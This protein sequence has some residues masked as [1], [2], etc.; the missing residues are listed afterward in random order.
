MNKTKRN[1]KMQKSFPF[2]LL[3]FFTLCSYSQ[4]KQGLSLLV[5]QHEMEKEMKQGGN[6]TENFIEKHAV[7]KHQGVDYLSCMAVVSPNYCPSKLQAIGVRAGEKIG[8]F[9]TLRI[10]ISMITPDLDLPG[11]EY[12]DIARKINPN[13]DKALKD[14]R[15]DSAHLGVFLPAPVSGKN[16]II[17][18]TDWGFDYTHP[19]FYDTALTNTRILAAWDQFRH[20]GPSPTGFDYGTV[21]ENEAQLFAA[22]CDT[23]NIYQYATHGSHVAGIAAGSGAGTIYKGVA[24]DA[25]LLFATFLID[26]AAVA[27]A[28]LW[29][30]NYA[31]NEGKR[32][33]INMSWGLY[34]MGHLDGTSVLSQMID[35]MSDD[36][37]VFV[38]SAGNNGNVNFHIKK[39]FATTSDTMKTIVK[40]D[41]YA[42]YSNM[43]GQSIS[44]WGSPNDTFEISLVV[45]DMQNN[46]LSQTPFYSTATAAAYEEDY[47]V[48]NSDTVFYNLAADSSNFFS[49]RPHFR[50][51]VRN[52]HASSYKVALFATS[53]NATVHFWNVIELTNDVG[54]WG[55]DFLALNSQW[56]AGD[57]FYGIGEPA[58][59]ESVITVAS[60]VPE[61]L[62]GNGNLGG[63]QISNF[64][65]FGPIIDGRMKPDISAPGSNI[66]SSISSFTSQN[67]PPMNVVETVVFQGRSYKFVRF[68][69]TSMS[70]PHV[71]GIVALLLEVNPLLT[72][73]EVKTLLKQTAREDIRTGVIPP[74]GSTRW[75]WGKVNAIQALYLALNIQSTQFMKNDLFIHVFPNPCENSLCFSLNYDFDSLHTA[76]V[77]D[78]HGKFMQSVE[79]EHNETCFNVEKFSSGTYV[80][81]VET[82]KGWSSSKFVKL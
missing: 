40:F 55:S 25:K 20:S 14:T 39:E 5:F 18:I 50:L 19:M 30:K 76:Y 74:Q 79:V 1:K 9:A 26:E 61:I 33:V 22:Q 35:Q 75:G 49:Q 21:F 64:S 66:C 69:G 58:C 34:N 45:L 7:H 54:N 73:F 2:L 43:W 29:M 82:N 78:I 24:F 17:G 10:P 36:G 32:L 62:L 77:F 41:N 48:V 11:V 47:I 71:A 8:R 4:T 16:V 65:S 68:S 51:R 3:V 42:Y 38:S 56:T 27:D 15:V 52:T 72:P 6:N 12:I 70:S 81:F 23:F 53:A 80:L 59:T 13:L 44:M 37:V 57:N 63:G 67:I 60:H 46:I 28:F 31:V